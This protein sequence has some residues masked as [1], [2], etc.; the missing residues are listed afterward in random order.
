MAITSLLLATLLAAPQ[1]KATFRD[2]KF[3]LQFEYPKTWKARSGRGVTTIEI[4]FEEKKTATVQL[5]GGKFKDTAEQWQ[6]IQSEVNRAMGRPVERQWQ[7]EFLGVPMLLTKVRY[8]TKKVDT[9]A[10]TGLLYTAFEMKMNFRLEAPAEVAESAENQWHDVLL[11]LRTITGE[12]PNPEDPN[13][14]VEKPVPEKPT[15]VWKPEVSD[16]PP[17][18]GK[19]I[20]SVTDSAGVAYKVYVPEGWALDG[21]KLVD[22]SV[23]GEVTFEIKMGVAQDA[24]SALFE[25]ARADLDQ[26]KSV[27]LR[28]DPAPGP[29]GSGALVGK[30]FRSGRTDGGFL[31]VGRVV[32]VCEGVYWTVRYRGTSQ[33]DYRKD[34]SALDALVRLLYAERA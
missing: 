9:V 20:R 21:S 11:S 25:G 12:L 14:P 31:A 16:K 6:L 24:S 7:E 5:F 34:R 30:V 33:Q 17:V 26:F 22:K 27:D 4:P 10:I 2:P 19:Q 15:T 1:D 29:V 23:K 32:G 8:T 3:G 13:R 28:E 18:R